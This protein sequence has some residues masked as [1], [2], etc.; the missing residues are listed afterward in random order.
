MKIKHK[1]LFTGTFDPFTRGHQNIVERTL[2]LMDEVV[3]GIGVNDSKRCLFSLEKRLEMITKLYENEPRVKVATYRGLTVDFAKEINAT[4]IVRGLRC[5]KDFE[6][7]ESMAD[8]NRR[9]NGIETL[10]LFTLPNF[11]SVS[12]SIVRELIGYGKDV[13]EFIPKGMK[14]D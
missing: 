11:N 9:L 8:I 3:I 4:C 10:L 6:Y 5:V 1:A 12:S 13:S 14:L 2:N 7:E